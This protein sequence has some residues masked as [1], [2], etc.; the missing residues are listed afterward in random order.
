MT[1][2]AFQEVLEAEYGK[3]T[4]LGIPSLSLAHFDRRMA[5]M[6]AMRQ[7]NGFQTEKKATRR[8]ADGTTR[9]DRK[10]KAREAA[11]ARVSEDRAPRFMHRAARL[12]ASEAN[13][14]LAA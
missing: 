7:G 11:N 2:N 4:H 9:G 12:W 8:F 13:L 1:K 3:D 5:T 14:A 10:S 6:S